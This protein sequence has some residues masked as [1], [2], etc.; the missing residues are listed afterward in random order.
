MSAPLVAL[1][2]GMR[3]DGHRVAHS[4][5]REKLTY[6]QIDAD[7]PRQFPESDSGSR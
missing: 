3:P 4:F 2:L 7:T 6:G 1:G 5:F